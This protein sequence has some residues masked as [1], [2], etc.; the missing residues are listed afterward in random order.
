MTTADASIRGE[1]DP[2]S[3]NSTRAAIAAVEQMLDK[4]SDHLF[5]EEYYKALRGELRT[6]HARIRTQHGSDAISA[7]DFGGGPVPPELTGD[8]DRLRKEHSAMLG[9]L[10][11]IL[12]CVDSLVDL[13]LEDKDVCFTRI[14]ELIALLRRHEAEENRLCYLA[15]WRDVGGES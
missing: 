2:I 3:A 8:Y 12:R 13:P 15:V 6:L 10:D 4:A 9:S 5:D 14:R 7:G 11:R 1:L